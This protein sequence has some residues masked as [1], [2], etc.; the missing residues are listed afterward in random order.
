M[1]RMATD[2]TG[3]SVSSSSVASV[4]S[5]VLREHLP[6]T[7][8]P[9]P[10]PLFSPFP[11]VQMAFVTSAEWPFFC[12]AVQGGRGSSEGGTWVLR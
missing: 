9:A 1:T 2:K 4:Q 5:V 11:P 12:V 10:L 8:H 7:V 3:S 6:E